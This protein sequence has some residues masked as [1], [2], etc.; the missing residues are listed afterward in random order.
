MAFSIVTFGENAILGI[1]WAKMV[2]NI[3]FHNNYTVND[4]W[5]ENGQLIKI[6][7]LH[8]GLAVLH[9]VM[10]AVVFFVLKE[11]GLQ[12]GLHNRAERCNH[13]M[14]Q[15]KICFTQTVFLESEQCIMN[16]KILNSSLG[17]R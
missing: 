6:I 13:R 8:D 12:Y 4:L 17:I 5:V 16:R 15:G 7:R 10:F 2:K 14:S 11:G 1:P 3:C 9:C